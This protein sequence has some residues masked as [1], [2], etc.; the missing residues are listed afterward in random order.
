MTNLWGDAYNSTQYSTENGLPRFPSR[1]VAPGYI[2]FTRASRSGLPLWGW[3]LRGSL[4]LG[5]LL[6]I[7]PTQ[8][9]FPRPPLTSSQSRESF[10]SRPPTGP[11]SPTLPVLSF[12]PRPGGA[13][14]CGSGF[15]GVAPGNGWASSSGLPR[16]RHRFFPRPTR[17][18]PAPP[19]REVGEGPCPSRPPFLLPSTRPVPEWRRGREGRRAGGAQAWLWRMRFRSQHFVGAPLQRMDFPAPPGKATRAKVTRLGDAIAPVKLLEF[20][21]GLQ[22][23]FLILA[24]GE[25]LVLPSNPE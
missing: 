1:L 20:H 15:L 6:V 9:T 5:F 18:Q 14:A 3:L 2:S 24:S 13:E 10:R 8:V 19:R 23:I 4:D 17:G 11:S 25:A 7:I 22:R 21:S 12:R 16:R